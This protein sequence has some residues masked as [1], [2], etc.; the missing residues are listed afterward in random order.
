M[1]FSF[2]VKDKGHRDKRI[3]MAQAKE[4]NAFHQKEDMAFLSDLFR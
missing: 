1:K 2:Q 3:T 4:G